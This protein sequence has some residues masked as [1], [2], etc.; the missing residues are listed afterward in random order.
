MKR[1]TDAKA[2]QADKR[3]ARDAKGH[4]GHAADRGVARKPNPNSG[5]GHFLSEEELR[6]ELG[7]AIDR[8]RG[9]TPAPK[10]PRSSPTRPKRSCVRVARKS[11]MV[12]IGQDLAARARF[13]PKAAERAK[14]GFARCY[15]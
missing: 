2:I 12:D 14:P 1:E 4:E 13:D 3:K 8:R 10:R 5:P 9:P 11:P 15:C 7:N 6:A